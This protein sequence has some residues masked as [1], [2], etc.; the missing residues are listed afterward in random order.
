MTNEP[1]HALPESEE[2]KGDFAALLDHVKQNPLL[3][4]AAVVFLVACALVGI[5]YRVSTSMEDRKVAATYARAIDMTDPAERAAALEEVASGGSTFA[6]I[7]L[8][9][10]GEAALS[11]NDFDLAR[12]SFEQLQANHPDFEQTP[13]AVEGV[14]F[15]LEQQ[16]DLEGALAKYEEVVAKWPNSFAGRRQQY[17]IGGCLEQLGKLKEAVQAYRDQLQHFPSSSVALRAQQSLER[18]RGT[19]AELFPTIESIPADGLTVAPEP[20]LT[21]DIPEITLPDQEPANEEPE[22]PVE[23]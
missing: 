2:P 18:L 11:A 10:R 20:T 14:G 13:D 1:T 16:D 3:Y 8:Y 9:M 19:N 7:A 5:L 15:I 4:A 23:E 6:P 17:N 21:E 12:K 22:T